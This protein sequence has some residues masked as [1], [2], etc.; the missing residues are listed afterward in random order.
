MQHLLWFWMVLKETPTMDSQPHFN[1]PPLAHSVLDLIGNTPL[2]ELHQ[3]QKGQ[4][5]AGRI[6][7]KMELFNP[8]GSKKDRVA[9]SMIRH[10]KASGKLAPGQAVVEVT[11]GNTG[12]GLAI[13]C[14]ALGHP[15]YAVMSAG[16]TRE[17]AQMMRALGAEVVLVEQAPGSCPGQ[18]NGRD[19]KSVKERCAKLVAELGAFFV[20]QFENPANP[21]AH[22]TIT[23]QEIW[24]QSGGQIDAIVGFVGSGGALGGL[25]R[26][27]Q[28]LKPAI[29]I[30]VVE[31][32]AA[33]S[34]ASGC[35]SDAGHAIQGGGYG[36]EKLSLMHDVKIDGY[37]T[38][39]DDDAA[40]AARMLASQEGI[41]AGYSTGA[42]LHASIELLRGK[43][44]GSS[45]VMFVCDTG[46][47][48]L[49]TGLYP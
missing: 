23:S 44:K 28:K 8:G 43:E 10:A 3:I 24:Q 48:Y 45:I 1:P 16:N 47:K 46:M 21:L 20:D 40:A 38:C 26:G 42:Q 5:Y 11:S 36:R 4:G 9:L 12:T 27:L 15:F 19:M 30:Y 29:R 25:A 7:A 41:L 39:A 17:R 2:M 32:A 35:C 37:L 6:L 49:S 33:S 13:V 22:E 14:R 18:V 34:L 31:P